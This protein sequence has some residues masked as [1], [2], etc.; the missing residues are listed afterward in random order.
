MVTVEAAYALAALVAVV[1]LGVA[2]IG[3]V[4][5]HLRCT[6]AAREVARLS[7][8]GDSAAVPVGARVAPS[9]AR[10]QVQRSGEQVVAT[11]VAKVPLLPL[12]DVS[13]R[14]VAA[15]EPSAGDGD[16]VAG[17]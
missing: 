10:I 2:A 17:T 3:G 15:V 14:S 7:A 16:L 12:L 5:A 1:V 4:V 11:V 13:A 9:G 6:D 8:A